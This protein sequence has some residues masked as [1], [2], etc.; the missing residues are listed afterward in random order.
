MRVFL[1]ACVLFPSVL[2]EILTGVAAR[3]GFQPLWSERVLT[4]WLMATAR[5]GP[6]ASAH[7][8]SEILRLKRAFPD[9]LCPPAPQI[10]ALLDLPDTADRHVLASAAAAGAEVLTTLNL[11]DFPR[12]A[13]FAQNMTAQSPDAFLMAL[14]IDQP[15]LIEQAVAG[16]QA[17]TELI[18]GRP[19]PVRALLKRASL[20]RLGKA[21]GD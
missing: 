8:Q 17:R 10:E 12:Y 16:V 14:W 6:E 3:G 19:Q 5:L 9:A 11:R 1:D 7:A 13:L 20:P 15:A 21:L 4:E 18:S 2:R